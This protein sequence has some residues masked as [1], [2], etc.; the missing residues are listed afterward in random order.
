MAVG[1]PNQASPSMLAC[2]WVVRYE[3]PSG[4]RGVHAH[5]ETE[6]EAIEGVGTAQE[7]F[8]KV[9]I[10]DVKVWIAKRGSPW[11][12][13]ESEEKERKLATSST[14]GK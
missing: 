2:P 4:E 7:W 9:G 13:S 6:G 10:A 5:C 8:R 1:D 12:S 3:K 11:Q 14:K